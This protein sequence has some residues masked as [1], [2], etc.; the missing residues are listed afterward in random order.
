MN[1]KI[2]QVILCGGYGS[3]I[4]HI[5]NISKCLININNKPFISYVI[6]SISKKIVHNIILCTGHQGA[7][8]EIYRKLSGN[9]KIYLSNED[10]P[11]GTG[12]ALLNINPELL[13]DNV[14][15]M[16]GDS[17]CNF[18]ITDMF[19]KHIKNCADVSIL[20]VKNNIR[21]DAGYVTVDSC[22]EITNFSE[23]K[24]TKKDQY[25]NAGIY[26]INKNIILNENYQKNSNIS[27]ETELIPNWILKYKVMAYVSS[28]SLIDIGTPE[29]LTEAKLTFG[30]L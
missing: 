16:N 30:K 13:T 25:I 15:L 29:R 9:K 27:M 4:A 10:K 8:Y 3:R 11:L 6:D 26:I 17:I 23:K 7:E 19:Q 18:D 1:F 20:L 21:K 2:S 12:G 5:E 28:G 24:Y 22:G 14:L